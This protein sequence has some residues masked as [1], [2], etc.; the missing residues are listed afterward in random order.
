MR[1]EPIVNESPAANVG[2]THAPAS[3][4]VSTKGY[5][6]FVDTARRPVFLLAPSAEL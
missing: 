2:Y 4:Y 3:F 1:W 5:G 6:V